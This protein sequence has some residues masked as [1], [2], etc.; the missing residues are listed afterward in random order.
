MTA[1]ENNKFIYGAEILGDFA[2]D[3]IHLPGITVEL[4][5][6]LQRLHARYCDKI[7]AD[8]RAGYISNDNT[9]ESWRVCI[10]EQCSEG[11]QDMKMRMQQEHAQEPRERSDAEEHGTYNSSDGRA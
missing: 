8:S 4:S 7:L 9:H 2:K 11:R 6:H 1:N 3:V 10:C 5:E